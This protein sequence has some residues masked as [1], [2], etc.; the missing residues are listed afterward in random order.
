MTWGK[1]DV[2][3]AMSHR[4]GILQTPELA[5]IQVLSWTC[6]PLD[7]AGRLSAQ[8]PLFVAVNG[9]PHGRIADYQLAPGS[10]EEGFRCGSPHCSPRGHRHCGVETAST[11]WTSLTLDW[12]EPTDLQGGYS[13]SPRM[14]YTLWPTTAG[15]TSLGAMELDGRG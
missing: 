9:F 15:G 4:L 1:P 7:P 13:A 5:I 14:L 11:I 8:R 10:S 12:V 2:E 6:N 3:L